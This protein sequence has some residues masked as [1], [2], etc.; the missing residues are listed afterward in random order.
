MSLPTEQITAA[1]RCGGFF[2]SKRARKFS[3]S[4][5][6]A[7]LSERSVFGGQQQLV[8]WGWVGGRCD[9]VKWSIGLDATATSHNV[10]KRS[11]LFFL[12]STN[13]STQQ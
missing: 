3:T 2:Y 8:Q 1:Q 13:L 11:V 9:G 10:Y 4:C 7:S 5:A 12:S 6:G